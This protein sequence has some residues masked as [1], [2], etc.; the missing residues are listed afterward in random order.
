MGRETGRSHTGARSPVVIF[1]ETKVKGAFVIEP[2]KREDERGFFGRSWCKKEFADHK[3]DPR[4]VQCNISL[5]RKKGTLRGMHYQAG[6]RGEAKLVRCTQGA[7]YDVIIDLSPGSPTFKQHLAETL[8]ARDHRMLYVPEGFAHGFQALDDNTEVF[9]Q[10]SE[11]YAP[12]YACGV[13]WND[14]SF[15]IKW[16]ICEPIMAERDRSYPDFVA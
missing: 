13:R 15:G 9:Y 10:L 1:T 11:F 7:I 5:N 2:E 4:V 6:P 3:L 8:N 14:P 12:E 16:P